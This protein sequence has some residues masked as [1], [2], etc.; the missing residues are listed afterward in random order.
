[1]IAEV[2]ACRVRS[3]AVTFD[4]LGDSVVFVRRGAEAEA[5]GEGAVGGVGSR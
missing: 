3:E 5:E 1:M 4:S 2:A